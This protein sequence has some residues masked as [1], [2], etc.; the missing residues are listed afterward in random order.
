[1]GIP[2]D[3]KNNKPVVD[4]DIGIQKIALVI[5]HKDKENPNQDD[6]I[7]TFI[8]NNPN[9]ATGANITLEGY[10]VDR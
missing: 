4:K 7:Y 10:K 3:S 9:W 2:W 5:K 1:V 8:N 6:V